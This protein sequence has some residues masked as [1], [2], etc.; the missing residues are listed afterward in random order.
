M[1]QY[2]LSEQINRISDKTFE[3]MVVLRGNMHYIFN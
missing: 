3:Y 1:N 2:D